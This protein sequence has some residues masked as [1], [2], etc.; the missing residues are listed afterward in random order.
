[1]KEIKKGPGNIKGLIPS[2]GTPDCHSSCAWG[3]AEVS[4]RW[5]RKRNVTRLF[6]FT[7]PVSGV[8]RGPGLQA[9]FPRESWSLSFSGLKAK[10]LCGQAGVC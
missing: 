2:S 7:P 5:V 4:S 10:R 3:L 8:L 9:S 6:N 1:M